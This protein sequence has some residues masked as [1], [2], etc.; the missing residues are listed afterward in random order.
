MDLSAITGSGNGTGALG[1]ST[2]AAFRDADF[3]AIML[4]EVANQDPF[5]PME[6][7]KLVENMQKLQELA[8]TRYQEH[9]NNLRWAQELVGEPITIGQSNL[10]PDE[11]RI[12]RERGLNP[13]TGFGFVTGRVESYRVLGENVWLT[14]DGAD[15]QI[16]KLQRIEPAPFDGESVAGIA[17][18][19]LGRHVNYLGTADGGPGGSGRVSDVTWTEDGQIILTVDGQR[20]PFDAIRGIGE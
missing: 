19:L 4:A 9:R 2:S 12:L 13:D 17:G 15:Y 3:L 16:D 8:N 1:G 6:T 11:E 20:V 18:G 7:S 14:I 10:T 5:E